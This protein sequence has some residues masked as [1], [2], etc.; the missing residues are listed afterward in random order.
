MTSAA[1]W[2][3]AMAIASGTARGSISRWRSTFS[4]L[5]WNT[6]D[7]DP[8]NAESSASSAPVSEAS[9]EQEIVLA[10]TQMGHKD[11]A[12]KEAAQAAIESLGLEAEL[13]A[14]VWQALRATTPRRP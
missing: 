1:A 9:L 8:S 12:A 14:L 7:P 10:L 6:F 11:K 4:G 13:S 5:R 3:R 2:R